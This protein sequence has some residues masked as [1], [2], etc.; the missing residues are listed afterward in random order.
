MGTRKS[1]MVVAFA[2]VAVFVWPTGS[3]VQLVGTSPPS[4]PGCPISR[5]RV[6]LPIPPLRPAAFWTGTVGNATMRHRGG[7]GRSQSPSPN[8]S[9]MSGKE[10]P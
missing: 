1:A 7:C 3:G 4:R 6:R 5:R 9:F 10:A 8:Q 2:V